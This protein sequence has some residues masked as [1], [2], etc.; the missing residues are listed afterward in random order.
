MELG[1]LVL[2][3]AVVIHGPDFLVAA[4]V[5]DESNLCR[6]NSRQSSGEF[7]DDFICELVR[8]GAHLRFGG[9][10]AVDLSNHRRQGSVPNIVEPSLNLGVGSVDRDV[11]K[12]QQLRGGGR[13]GPTLVIDIGGC[14]RRL[15]RIVALAHHVKD[16][17]VI[18]VRSEHVAEQ[19]GERLGRSVLGCEVRHAHA[20]F[21]HAQPCAGL[22][23]VLRG[24]ARRNK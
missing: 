9:L 17:A 23:P 6:G 11:S 15:Q 7:P 22:E 20:S 8:E 10:P 24:R 12:G 4:A 14:R 18:Q 1:Q 19:S 16:A 3:L 13:A 5:A 21:R 2:V